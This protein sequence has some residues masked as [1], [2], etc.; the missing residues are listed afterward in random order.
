ML[1]QGHSLKEIRRLS[2]FAVLELIHHSPGKTQK[3]KSLGQA[4][5]LE[6]WKH[7]IMFKKML[8]LTHGDQ[9]NA[10]DSSL[11]SSICWTLL[12]HVPLPFQPLFA[13]AITAKTIVG[14]LL[15]F[16]RGPKKRGLLEVVPL[17]ASQYLF[18]KKCQQFSIGNREVPRSCPISAEVSCLTF[19]SL[20]NKAS[21]SSSRD[22]AQTL[23]SLLSRDG[24]PLGLSAVVSLSEL[25]KSLSKS[26]GGDI[27]SYFPCWV[28][29]GRAFVFET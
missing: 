7:I 3:I 10:S 11:Y 19:S 21:I 16:F 6:R 2:T 17:K 29:F 8:I 28:G 5:S 14:S 24:E 9:A 22:I 15:V 1:K 23:S 12:L 25:V 4:P 26:S 27:V 20:K 18:I 13:H